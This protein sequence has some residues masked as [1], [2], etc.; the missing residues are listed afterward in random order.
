MGGDTIRFNLA[1]T[2]L[3]KL[4]RRGGVICLAVFDVGLVAE[5]GSL[6]GGHVDGNGFLILSVFGFCISGTT[7]PEGPADSF[8][9]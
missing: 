9:G 4:I 8:D 7:S 1:T 6:P 2:V 3:S 5:A